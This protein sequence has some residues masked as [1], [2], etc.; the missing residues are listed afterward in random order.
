MT[1]NR[2]ENNTTASISSSQWNGSLTNV[3][4]S[5]L[6]ARIGTILYRVG[7]THRLLAEFIHDPLRISFEQKR[8]TSFKTRMAELDS[9]ST[10]SS[11]AAADVASVDT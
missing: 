1:T 2:G 3:V 4:E 6:C 9:C 5:N 7:V 11:A 8:N 10:A